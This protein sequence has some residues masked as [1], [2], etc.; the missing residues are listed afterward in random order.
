M[1]AVGL[2]WFLGAGS[3]QVQVDS[4][5]SP[6]LSFRVPLAFVQAGV[7]AIPNRVFAEVRH[8]LD[9]EL[10]EGWSPSFER[11]CDA[12]V[13]SPDG[14]FVQVRSD[15]ERID[16]SKKRGSF[17]ILVEDGDETVRV[18]VPIKA[19]RMLGRKLSDDL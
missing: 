7:M 6:N 8:E 16:I 9:D 5:D 17:H 18:K 12:L 11:I 14:L 1:L 19:I 13:D 2:S 3:L 4:P 15:D 10:G